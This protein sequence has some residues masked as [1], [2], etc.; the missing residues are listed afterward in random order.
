VTNISLTV[1]GTDRNGKNLEKVVTDVPKSISLLKN[2][3]IT[4][5]IASNGGKIFSLDASSLTNL[6][7]IEWY[8]EENSETPVYK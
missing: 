4:E 2:V 7:T 8:F 5:K 3:V 1:V 6:G